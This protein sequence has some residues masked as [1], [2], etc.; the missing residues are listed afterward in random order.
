MS[1]KGFVFILII[2]LI[3]A[4]NSDRKPEKVKILFENLEV[5]TTGVNF[6]NKI[7]NTIELNILNY[8]YFYNG[9]GVA[10]GDFNNDNLPD[11]YFTANQSADELYINHGDFKF[12]NVTSFSGIHNSENWSTGVTTVDINNDGFMDIYI[13]KVGDYKTVIGHNLLY[14]NQGLNKDS[15]PVF[16]EMSLDYGLDF[17]GF[18]TQSAFLDFDLDGDLDMFLLNHSVY[19]NRNYGRGDKRMQYDSL[20]GDRLYRNDKGKFVDVTENS[21]IFQGSIGYGLGISVSDINNDGYPDIYVGNDFFEND[22]LYINQKDG[23][24][25]EITHTDSSILGHTTHYSMGND[26]AD[27][28]ND[29]FPDIISMDMLPE[30]L[31]SYKTSG[32]EYN[33]QIYQ[34]YLKNG[35]NPQYMQNTLHINNGRNVTFSETAFASGLAAT[36]WSWSP[37]IADFDNDG[38]KDVFITNGI[39][40]A[41]NDMDFIS[42]IANEDIQKKINKGMGPK[43]LDFIKKIPSKK[44]SN[45]FFKN[46]ANNTFED[47]SQLWASLQPSYSNGAV[48]SD[49]DNDGDLDIVVN[50]VNETAFIL[51]NNS[52]SISQNNFLKIKF[53]GDSLNI[54]GIGAKVRVYTKSNVS[55][56][57]NYSTRGYLSSIEPNLNFGLGI[58]NVIDSVQ[59]IWPG[60]KYQTLQSVN[61]NE[62]ITFYYENAKGDYSNLKPRSKGSYLVN[63]PPLFNFTHKDQETVEFN[64]D[65]LIPFASTNLGPNVSVADINNDGREDVF[66][67]GSKGQASQ[68]FVQNKDFGFSITQEEVFNKDAINEDVSHIFFDANNDGFKDLIV[69]SGGNEYKKGTPL[70]PRLYIN[71]KGK[72]VKDS[73]QFKSIEINASKVSAVDFDNDDDLDIC[74]TANLV[75]WQFG[76]TPNQYLFKNDGHGDFTD[77]TTSYALQFK[78]IGNVQDMVWVDLNNDNYKDLIVVGYWMPISVFL[79][80][81]KQLELQENNNL[82]NTNGWDNAVQAEDFDND[83]DID[84]VVGN[85]GLNTRLTAS[86]DKPMRLYRNDFDDNGSIEPIVTYYYKDEE[87]PF[88]SKDELVKQMPFLNKKYLSYSD[89][90]NAKFKDILPTKKLKSALEKHVFNLASCYYE[91]L[92]SNTFKAHKL[93]FMAQLSTVN[94]IVVYDFNDDNFNDLLLIGNNYEIS[95]QLGRQD[96]SHGILLFNDT[97]GGFI[98]ENSQQF[99]VSGASRNSETIEIKGETFYIITRNNNTPIF[100]KLNKE[101]D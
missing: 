86:V 100:L 62:T 21:G 19:P 15:I 23:T 70:K 5:N 56:Q 79:N 84:I 51:K 59:V 18:S 97:K 54:N 68:L 52:E 99:D 45:Y 44:I 95:T 28:N 32:L 64:R 12:K 94:D 72:F 31:K 77:V 91:N 17:K 26:I 22:Y 33:Y 69:V 49:L 37:L 93:P 13:C 47:V 29:G 75:P 38:Y 96:A 87:T 63:V 6:Q 53:K 76:V 57:E 35:Y 88:A 65:P 25:K 83:G 74:I 60:G 36:D 40:G 50:N 30:V 1:Y 3:F 98:E 82:F 11:L 8:L 85:W 24:F 10:V 61:V 42:F 71:N 81:G 67:S 9:S 80:N 2:L 27:I 14:I 4:C 41:T 90:A 16:K 43:D 58:T 39:L 34:N 92:G 89:F 101:I 66:I 7:K 78:T 20:S 46:K 48:Y 55:S 73:L